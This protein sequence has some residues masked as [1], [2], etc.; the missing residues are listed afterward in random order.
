MY[1]DRIQVNGPLDDEL[2]FLCCYLNFRPQFPNELFSCLIVS[3]GHS[4]LHMVNFSSPGRSRVN[5]ASVV[6]LLSLVDYNHR[7]AAHMIRSHSWKVVTRVIGMT[8]GMW[9]WRKI[10]PSCNRCLFP[11]CPVLVWGTSAHLPTW[12]EQCSTFHHVCWCVEKMV[13]CFSMFLGGSIL[14]RTG[15]GPGSW[16]INHGPFVF[17][18]GVDTCPV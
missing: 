11:C 2:A 4:L 17:K 5:S 12:E 13:C 3:L 9:T 15:S 18:M 1:V 16:V 10:L 7:L 6:I 14:L 8:F